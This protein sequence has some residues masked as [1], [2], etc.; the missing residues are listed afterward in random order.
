MSLYTIDVSYDLSRFPYLFN[1]RLRNFYLLM[2]SLLL[3]T[4]PWIPFIFF[5]FHIKIITKNK[6]ITNKNMT[7][8]VQAGDKY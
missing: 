4:K 8:F 6:I 2:I 7:T 5:Y 1:I 3:N